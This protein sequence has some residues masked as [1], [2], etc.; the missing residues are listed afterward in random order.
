M[1]QTTPLPE[2]AMILP[3]AMLRGHITHLAH[4]HSSA[5][6]NSVLI[7]SDHSQAAGFLSVCPAT[8]RISPWEHVRNWHP[9]SPAP[10]TQ[11]VSLMGAVGVCSR[12]ALQ[13][14]LM[15]GQAWQGPAYI[16]AFFSV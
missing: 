6:G 15:Q 14:M 12:R 8:A 2:E 10:E 11:S 1:E 16:M 13:L 7:M 4:S 9:G 3:S 5:V